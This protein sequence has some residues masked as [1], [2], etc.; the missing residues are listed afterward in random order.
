MLSDLF[1]ELLSL[2]FLITAVTA[3]VHATSLLVG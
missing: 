1:A 2:A 3:M